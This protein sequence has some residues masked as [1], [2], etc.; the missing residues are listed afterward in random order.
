MRACDAQ[1]IV[2]STLPYVAPLQPWF[3]WYGVGFNALIIITQGFESFV[4]WS[5]SG[6]FTAYISLILFVVLYVGHKAWTRCPFVPAAEADLLTGRKEVDEM[7][8]PEAEPK[9]I[10][11]KMLA[12]LG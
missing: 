11:G 2:R 7:Y 6:F 12:W 8:V 5:T 1:G 3:T 9:T 10:W 4:P